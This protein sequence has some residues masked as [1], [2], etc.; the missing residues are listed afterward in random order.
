MK[1]MLKKIFD[2]DEIVWCEFG[3]NTVDVFMRDMSDREFNKSCVW[4]KS[5][6]S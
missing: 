2:F 3:K 5:W 6:I 1:S 4:L